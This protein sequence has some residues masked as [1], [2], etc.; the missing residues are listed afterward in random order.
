MFFP[1][2][3]HDIELSYRPHS[4]TTGAIV[5]IASAVLL[6]IAFLWTRRSRRVIAS[7]AIER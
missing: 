4:V 7:R 5:S 2:G 3:E 6:T 1:A